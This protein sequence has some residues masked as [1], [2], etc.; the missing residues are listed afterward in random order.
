MPYDPDGDPAD[1]DLNDPEGVDGWPNQ[2]NTAMYEGMGRPFAELPPEEQLR[3]LTLTMR[4]WVAQRDEL[5]AL[6]AE[7]D[8]PTNDPR[9]WSLVAIN[10]FVMRLG[11]RITELGGT[12]PS[13][14]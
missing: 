1:F 8:A 10:D 13:V 7:Q 5:T 3:E 12:P 14:G 9:R 4:K 2:A 6:L 11:L